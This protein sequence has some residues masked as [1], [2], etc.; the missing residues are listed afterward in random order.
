MLRVFWVFCQLGWE[1]LYKNRRSTRRLYRELDALLKPYGFAL[2]AEHHKRIFFYTAQSAITNHWFS[3]L[4]GKPPTP[5]ERSHAIYL[6]AFTPIADDLMDSTGQTFEQLV[7]AKKNDTADAILFAYLLE[8]LQPLIHE[9]PLFATY[10]KKAHEAQNRSLKQLG[11]EKLGIEELKQISFDK[12]GYYTTLYRMVLQNPPK[13][14]EEAA[15][16]TLGAILQ[17]LNDLFDIYKDLHNGVQTLATNTADINYIAEVL[18]NLE[19]TFTTEFFA[20]DYPAKNKHKA[21]TAIMAIVTRGHVALAHYRKLQGEA[22]T[23]D[24][25]AYQRKPLIVDMEKLGNIWRNLKAT[26]CALR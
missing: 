18:M 10:F 16:Y 5:Q 17:V 2:N 23:L 19:N 22:T 26:K 13:K 20:L 25:A 15:I 9:S 7:R 14:G 6:G 12:G 1:I 8:K 21:Y 4:R 11:K 3:L 24:I